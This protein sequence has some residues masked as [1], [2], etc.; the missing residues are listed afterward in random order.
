LAYCMTNG[1]L[2]T[3][4]FPS[5]TSGAASNAL[6]QIFGSVEW[7]ALR[8]K[9]RGPGWHYDLDEAYVQERLRKQVDNMKEHPRDDLVKLLVGPFMNL[10]APTI[11]REKGSNRRFALV[12]R[13]GAAC[14]VRTVRVPI[15]GLTLFRVTR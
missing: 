2:R 8:W 4:P 1:S 13:L 5:A 9:D 12:I 6:S 15:S 3:Q 11:A 7:K 14:S 10:Y